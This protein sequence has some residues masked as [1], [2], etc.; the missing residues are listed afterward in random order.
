MPPV[1]IHRPFQ[2][3]LGSAVLLGGLGLGVLP[4]PGAVAHAALSGCRTDPVVSLSNGVQVSMSNSISDMSTNVSS[5]A[6]T[7]HG[8][9]RTTVTGVSYANS[10]PGV[11]ETFQ[12]I[13]DNN[14][15]NYDSYSAIYDKN[16]G[17]DVQYYT[18]VTNT[19]TGQVLS[20]S[21]QTHL[22]GSGQS[23]HIHLHLD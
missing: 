9:Q 3:L 4:S 14:A 22:S 11:P 10:T 6:Y 16:A 13:A 15:G 5:V 2:R 1:T 12:Y 7:L 19:V 23:L 20:Q 17:I 8:P 21:A 18:T